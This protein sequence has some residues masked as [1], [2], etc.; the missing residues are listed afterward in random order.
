MN[1]MGGKLIVHYDNYSRQ[2]KLPMFQ[3][4][5][6]SKVHQETTRKHV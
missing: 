6:R 5:Q 1:F 4:W 3:T 2:V